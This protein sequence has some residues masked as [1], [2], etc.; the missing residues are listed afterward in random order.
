MGE[1]APPGDRR[2]GFAR[3]VRRHQCLVRPFE[4]NATQV[5]QRRGL[6]VLAKRVLDGTGVTS[7]AAAMSRMVMSYSALP[8]MKSSARRNMRG[9]FAIDF[10]L[11][12]PS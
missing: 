10:A 6:Q 1:P 2:D 3:R 7:A 8:S 5:L 4:S 9:Y 11:T 12:M